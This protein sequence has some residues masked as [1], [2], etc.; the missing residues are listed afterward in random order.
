MHL[1][2]T[3]KSDNLLPFD[4]D[5]YYYGKIFNTNESLHYYGLLWELINWQND[6][7]VIFGK[8]IITNRKVAFYAAS[9]DINYKY[10]KITKNT[11]VFIP[12]LLEIKEKI[13]MITHQTFNSCLLNLYQNGNEG[14]GWHGD[15][16]KELKPNGTIASISFGAERNFTFKHNNTKQRIAIKLENGSLLTMEKEI[17][18]F[19]K[20]SMPKSSKI[21]TPR[22]NLTF[23]TIV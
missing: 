5:A 11:A 10:S 21:M 14:M 20:H 6:E 22:I 9:A 4:G 16:E 7:V 23:R 13:E 17:Q 15:N 18:K 3:I 1:F 12:V 19:W 2:D 8:K